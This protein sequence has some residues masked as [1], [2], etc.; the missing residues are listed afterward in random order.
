MIE[1]RR[2]RKDDTPELLRLVAEFHESVRPRYPFTSTYVA[3]QEATSYV[4]VAEEDGQLVGYIWAY[5]LSQHVLFVPQAYASRRGV[6]PKLVEYAAAEVEHLGYRGAVT[7]AIRDGW[8][9]FERV[10]F[11]PTG[12][13]MEMSIPP[14]KIRA[15]PTLDADEAKEVP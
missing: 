12:V 8:K 9:A 3:I 6:F 11:I 10:G 15:L 2:A 4:W 14:R 13:V 1:V 5:P 7:I